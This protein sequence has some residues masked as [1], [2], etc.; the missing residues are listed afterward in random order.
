VLSTSDGV[1][2][3]FSQISRVESAVEIISNLLPSL[4]EAVSRIEMASTSDLLGVGLPTTV[5]SESE[6]ERLSR[7]KSVKSEIK[8]AT[9]ELY[10]GSATRQKLP[11]WQVNPRV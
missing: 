2:I 4:A 3:W 10:Y 1:S 8:N 11:V 6:A 9:S 5:N 7:L